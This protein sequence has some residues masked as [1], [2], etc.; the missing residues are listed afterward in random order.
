MEVVINVTISLEICRECEYV[1]AKIAKERIC[2]VRNN[3][4][5]V[6]YIDNMKIETE[7]KNCASIIAITDMLWIQR[8]RYKG[9]I[10]IELFIMAS[11]GSHTH[12]GCWLLRGNNG[13]H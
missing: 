11:N 5:V 13:D 3:L 8:S 1:T 9:D 7:V 4:S 2:F 6:K 10:G 12:T